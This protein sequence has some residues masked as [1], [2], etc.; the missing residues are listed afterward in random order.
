MKNFPRIHVMSLAFKHKFLTLNTIHRELG[1]DVDIRKKTFCTMKIGVVCQFDC[2]PGS[3]LGPGSPGEP[4][5]PW[6]PSNPFGPISGDAGFPFSPL[7]PLRP[8]WPG[9]PGFPGIPGP[10]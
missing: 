2:L 6:G 7:I 1:K 9:S 3:P 5:S 10:G 8:G 4:R